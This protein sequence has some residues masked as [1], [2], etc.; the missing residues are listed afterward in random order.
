MGADD[1]GAAQA[2]MPTLAADNK[3]AAEGDS[4]PDADVIFDYCGLA[5][6]EAKAMVK[7]DASPDARLRHDV[8]PEGAQKVPLQRQS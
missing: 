5:D 2:R 6:D 7:P 4:V 1:A 8:G 3:I